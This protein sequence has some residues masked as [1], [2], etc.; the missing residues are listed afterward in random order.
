MKVYSNYEE[1]C[2]HL[3]ACR[4]VQKL[5]KLKG[6]SFARHCCKD[7]CTAYQSGNEGSWID[8]DEA[9]SYAR[10]GVSSIQSGYDSYD[11]Y[12]TC[13]LSGLTIGEILKYEEE[14]EE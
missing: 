10:E 13:D 3:R 1:D 8:V 12:C 7:E 2:I 5:G 9:I 11:V 6:H 14:E 4:R